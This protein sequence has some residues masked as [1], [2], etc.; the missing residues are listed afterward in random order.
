MIKRFRLPNFSR[1][2]Q[3]LIDLMGRGSLDSIHDFTEGPYRRSLL[4][5]QR[6]ENQVNV[7]RHYNRRLHIDLCTV[8]VPAAIE[9]DRSNAFGKNPALISAKRQK[10]RFVVSLQ[11]WK[12]P[13]IKRLEHAEF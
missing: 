7:V 9:N 11:M 5:D 8:I 4:M 13:P 1:S 2:L 10:V 3:D 6:R 12:S